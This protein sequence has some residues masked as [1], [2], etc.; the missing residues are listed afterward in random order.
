MNQLFLDFV[1]KHQ[2]I[3]LT[4]LG[5][6]RSP[7]IDPFIYSFICLFIYSFVFFSK[8]IIPCPLPSPPIPNRGF[9]SPVAMSGVPSATDKIGKPVCDRNGPR[10]TFWKFD[11]SSSFTRFVQQTRGV[12]RGDGAWWS[13]CIGRYRPTLFV[14]A[15]LVCLPIEI[16]REKG[17]VAAMG[18][19]VAAM[20]VTVFYIPFPLWG[21]LSGPFFQNKQKMEINDKLIS[22][23][24]FFF[25]QFFLLIQQ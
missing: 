10:T 14:G 4:S 23:R 20:S 15:W 12:E 18:S 22:K 11:V 8:L 19:I 16:F 9:I 25:S 6:I 1:S 13:Q 2:F 7:W 17:G 5:H 21:E 3:H 24:S